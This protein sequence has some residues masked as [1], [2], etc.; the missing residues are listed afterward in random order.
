MN[1]TN[2][3]CA[4]VGTPALDP[5]GVR[6]A[7]EE[8]RNLREAEL[9]LTEDGYGVLEL[10]EPAEGDVWTLAHTLDAFVLE[11]GPDSGGAGYAGTKE[12]S[13]ELVPQNLPLL[14]RMYEAWKRETPPLGEE[15]LEAFR[16]LLEK[17][18]REVKG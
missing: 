8:I 12:A 10:P 4:I 3:A 14:G 15:G 6:E 2:Y 17:T 18:A 5:A 13:A 16:E 11:A 9:Y 1:Y 7:L